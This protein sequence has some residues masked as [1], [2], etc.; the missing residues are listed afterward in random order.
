MRQR[1]APPILPVL[2]PVEPAV[3]GSHPQLSDAAASVLSVETVFPRPTMGIRYLVAALAV[4]VAAVLQRLLW[5][6]I[7]PSPQLLFYPAILFS[8]WFGGFGAGALTVLL[9]SVAILYFFLPPFSALRVDG[10]DDLVDLVVFG[11]MGLTVSWLM[12]RTIELTRR[13]RQAWLAARAASDRLE[14]A[15]RAREEMLAIMSHDVRSPL[16]AISLS[17][18][19]IQVA[20]QRGG[21]QER[22]RE[23]AERVKRSAARVDGL[24]RNLIDVAVLET[25]SLSL[26][27]SVVEVR[28]LLD[29]T[30][31]MFEPLAEEKG[32]RL[33]VDIASS[34]WVVCDRERIL[35][36]LENMIGNALKFA[37][38]GGA[39]EISARDQPGCV[40]FEV[41][42]S[43][44]GI[45]PENVDHIFDRHWKSGAAAGTGLGLYIAKAI[46]DAH[47]GN[48]WARGGMGTTVAFT[49][50]RTAGRAS[51]DPN[52]AHSGSNEASLFDAHV[53]KEDGHA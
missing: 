47:R 18:T 6:Y 29:E 9:S 24:L 45:A 38:P 8:A 48:I 31:L 17:T 14:Q 21:A 41:R 28:S 49:L 19:Q 2:L 26:T 36:V 20:L 25:G 46:V 42:D 27:P 5:P 30:V 23:A 43:G 10:M 16:H 22:I 15:G 13:T 53:S 39:V 32:V 35:Q 52:R 12:S 4:A 1:S 33:K 34:E 51:S 40:L 50:P 3:G 44:P 37:P 11:A 7:P